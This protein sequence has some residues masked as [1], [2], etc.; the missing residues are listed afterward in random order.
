MTFAT[1]TKYVGELSYTIVPETK[2]T[3]GIMSPSRTPDFSDD[4]YGSRALLR[5]QQPQ[6]KAGAVGI[7]KNLWYERQRYEIQDLGF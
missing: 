3:S 5:P 2:A 1:G 4:E 6:S 7:R